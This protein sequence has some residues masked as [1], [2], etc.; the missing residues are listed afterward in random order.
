[1]NDLFETIEEARE[2]RAAIMAESG[3][4]NPEQ[5][6]AVDLH[7]YE[8]RDVVRRFFPDGDAA[9]EYLGLVEKK[10]GKAQADKL[11]DDCRALWKQRQI[12]MAGQA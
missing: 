3:V 12:E 7:L 6:A 4:A 8:V 2:E 11:R 1:M 5:A 10:R 9:A